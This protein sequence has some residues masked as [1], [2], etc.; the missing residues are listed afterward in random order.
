MVS[1]EFLR[2]LQLRQTRLNRL[3]VE[4]GTIRTRT[5][6]LARSIKDYRCY[7]P[8]ADRALIAA[9]QG[10]Q[11]TLASAAALQGATNEILESG[12]QAKRE[13]QVGILHF[14]KFF[15][16][17]QKTLRIETR[18]LDE[19]LSKIRESISK[20]K[21]AMT[22]AINARSV[23]EARLSAH[24]AFEVEPLIRSLAEAESETRRILA[25]TTPL[26][27]EI[28]G[29][30][31]QTQV[32]LAEYRRLKTDLAMV[33]ADIQAASRFDERLRNAADGAQRARI[34]Q[35]CQ[36][37]FGTGSPAHVIRT[38]SGRKRQ[39]ENNT[40]KVGRR[41]LEE[42]E[43]FDRTIERLIIDG[44]NLCYEGRTFIGLTALQALLG[45][46]RGRFEI[47]V[48]FDASIRRLLRTNDHGISLILGTDQKVHVSPTRSAADEYLMKIAGDDARAFI[49]SNDRFAEFHDYDVV[50]SGR[51]LRF[52]VA[53][54]R[55]MVNALNVTAELTTG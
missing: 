23:A 2:P 26:E 18:R 29:M 41:I 45:E 47:A 22:A 32:H 5:S 38:R 17:E 28:R 7:E 53:E 19:Q 46:I 37:R 10:K 14:R 27:I 12:L 16:T 13:Q 21:D 9:L 44:N 25:L 31:S 33:N 36:V 20:S 40:P 8:E 30:E 4:L 50:K 51:V 54:G 24:A 15:S 42:L 1:D 11:V 52:M 39:L 35:E 49:L 48:I 6:A 3:K 34:H 43:K 55:I